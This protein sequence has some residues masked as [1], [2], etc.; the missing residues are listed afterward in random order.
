MAARNTGGQLL[1]LVMMV[2]HNTW[3]GVILQAHRGAAADVRRYQAHPVG[4]HR[5]AGHAV[6]RQLGLASGRGEAQ[7]VPSLLVVS[8]QAIVIVGR[9]RRVAGAYGLRVNARRLA[10]LPAC[11]LEKEFFFCVQR[12]KISD[13]NFK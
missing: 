13:E 12:F 9:V 7:I 11:L 8:V 3:R 4:A 1:L 10:A 5:L 2:Q 6:A